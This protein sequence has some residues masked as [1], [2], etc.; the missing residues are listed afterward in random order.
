MG[1][2]PQQYFDFIMDYAPYFYVI[3]GTGVD[4]EWERGPVPAAH[5]VDFL[6]QAYRSSQFSDETAQ[7]YSKVEELADYLVSI[8]CTNPAKL[9]YGGFQSKDN[10]TYY[11]SID[12]MRAIPR[13]CEPLS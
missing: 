1:T 4:P 5:A 9:A 3:P 12:A 8:Q 10:S 11:Y 6:V 7:I 2:V 13:Y